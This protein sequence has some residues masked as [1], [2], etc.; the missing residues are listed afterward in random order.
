MNILFGKKEP[1][2]VPRV[3]TAYGQDALVLHKLYDAFIIIQT[4]AVYEARFNFWTEAYRQFPEMADNDT[5]WDITIGR[6][7]FGFTEE[8]EAY[9][10][11]NTI[12]TGDPQTGDL[13]VVKP[14]KGETMSELA[15]VFSKRMPKPMFFKTVQ[16]A[17]D[18]VVMSCAKLKLHSVVLDFPHTIFT[19]LNR[20]DMVQEIVTVTQIL[21][22]SILDHVEHI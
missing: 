19:Y 22:V 4:E 20:E 8:Q 3:F 7:G 13:L 17:K 6:T 1:A 5:Y 15:M 9:Y 14:T 21:D 16:L 10:P 12:K 18:S 2:F 11:K